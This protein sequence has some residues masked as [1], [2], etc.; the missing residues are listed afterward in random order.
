MRAA[1][2]GCFVLIAAL[3]AGS[4]AA[5]AQSACLIQSVELPIT[6]VGLRPLAAARINDVE[7]KFILDSGAFFSDISEAAAARLHLTL[8]RAPDGFW[9]EGVGGGQR[10]NVVRVENFTLKKSSIP[11]VEF[12]V[13]PNDDDSGAVGLL[14]QNFLSIGDTEYDLANGA[15]RIVTPNE[16]CGKANLAYWA[17]SK[18]V[19]AVGLVRSNRARRAQH[20]VVVAAVNGK[21]IRAMIDSGAATSLLSLDAAKR[22]GIEPRGAGVVAAGEGGGIGPHKVK[23]WIAPVQ[24]FAIGSEVIRNTRLRIGEMEL[25]DA[26][27][28]IGADFLLAHRVYVA[29]S[30]G[31]VYFTYSG[32]PVFN[33]SVAGMPVHGGADAERETPDATETPADAAGYARRGA[34][35]A[36]RREFDLALADLDQACQLEPFSGKYF[37]E[38]ARV[39]LQIGQRTQATADLNE[40]LRLDPSDFQ[41]RL[42]RVRLYATDRDIASARAD[43]EVLDQQLAPQD[44]YRRELG[45]LYGYIGLPELALSEFSQWIASHG[46]DANLPTVRNSRCWVRALLGIELRDALKDCNEA[47]SGLSEKAAPLE[48]RGLVY[49]RMGELDKALDDYNQ[50]LAINPK[51]AWSLY[52]RGLARLRK[53]APGEGSADVA[54]AKELRPG[55]EEEG[56]KYGLTP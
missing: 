10:P 11:N 17:G 49:L 29:N 37:A 55:I 20:T 38:R 27:M 42:A 8:R 28:L 6:M 9:V 46:D 53:G 36:A 24:S 16:G 13:L 4:F 31:I 21:E 25:D 43:L 50:A 56:R 54:A 33:L 30:Q 48:S 22:A 45:G 32:G 41:A 15:V 44:N 23:I 3:A 5:P 51:L 35:R 7:V 19:V 1:R 12:I 47:V 34:A 39:R 26:D 52:G 2:S 14:G 40:A 18:P